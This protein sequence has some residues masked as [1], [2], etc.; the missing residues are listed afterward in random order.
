VLSAKAKRVIPLVLY[1]VGSICFLIGSV[2]SIY[3]LD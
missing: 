3:W 1:S 2:L